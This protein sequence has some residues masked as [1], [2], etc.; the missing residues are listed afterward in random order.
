M[1][2]SQGATSIR[3]NMAK[4]TTAKVRVKKVVSPRKAVVG[5]VD[6]QKE[7]AYWWLRKAE[8]YGKN[9]F[10]ICESGH[11]VYSNSDIF[12]I[13]DGKPV[14]RRFQNT[15]KHV[16][17][18]CGEKQYAIGEKFCPR[19]GLEFGKPYT[20]SF[21][22]GNNETNSVESKIAQAG[23]SS[24]WHANPNPPKA[25]RFPWDSDKILLC[26]VL[27]CWILMLLLAMR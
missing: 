18:K 9:G 5:F 7:A 25:R 24:V 13:T 22:A 15:T 26:L 11:M 2:R 17:N 6:D 21:T 27:A 3:N 20:M 8:E 14:D 1:K 23:G 4:K 19:D 10:G 16:C 12:C